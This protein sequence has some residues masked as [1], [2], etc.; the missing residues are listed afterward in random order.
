MTLQSEP[1]QKIFDLSALSQHLE[2]SCEKDSRV[3]LCHG[4]FDLLHVGH[5]KYLNQAKKNG[6]S[7]C[8][9]P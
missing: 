5:I 1:S 7:S 4:V 6:G 8:W 2:S 9:S 3:V